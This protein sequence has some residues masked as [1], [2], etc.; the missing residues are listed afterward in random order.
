MPLNQT[1]EGKLDQHEVVSRAACAKVTAP[2][3]AERAFAVILLAFGNDPAARWTFPDADAYLTHFPSVIRAF[4]GRAFA[5]GT[6][7]HVDGFAG[8]AMWLPPGV[9]ADE[10]AL[11]AIMQA[12]VPAERQADLFA[13]FE[14]MGSYHPGEPHWYLPLIGVDPA[15]QHK[16]YGSLLLRHGLAQCDRDHAPAYLESSNPANIP[17]YERHGFVVQGTIQVGSSPTIVPMLRAAR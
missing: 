16:G 1:G 17:L 4:G 2:S 7:I 6:G 5:H 13:V 15:H 8:A 11:G 12:T 3:D 9:H 14:R 10:E